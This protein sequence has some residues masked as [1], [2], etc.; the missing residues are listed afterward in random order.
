MP[1]PTSAQQ[2]ELLGVA[3][4][5]AGEALER[6]A[7]G[8]LAYLAFQG[9]TSRSKLAGLLWADVEDTK[10]RMNLRQRV[11][12]LK[13][14]HP[15]LLLG[16]DIL[17]LNPDVQVDALLEVPDTAGALLESHDYSDCEAFFEWL[18]AKRRSLEAARF[19]ALL[20][21]VQKLE[22]HGQF[23]DALV[24]A[25][26]LVALEPLSE[27]NH[28][29]VMRLH[30]FQSD[31]PSA[32]LAFE[33]CEEILKREL[34]VRPLPETIELMQLIERGQE[35]PQPMLAKPKIPLSVLRPPVLAGREHEWRALEI[36]WQDGQMLA[37][38]GEPGMGKTRLLLDFVGS[39]GPYT[40]IEGRP[41]DEAV[42]YSTFARLLRRTLTPGQTQKIVLL[43][44][45]QRQELA[46]IV[47]ELEPE[48]S[49]SLEIDQQRLFAALHAL[50]RS[51]PARTV[52]A[53][54]LQF[55][56]ANSLGI[57]EHFAAHLDDFR[58]AFAY[59]L[60]DLKNTFAEH[61]ENLIDAGK[62]LRLQLE[63]LDP[64]ALKTL[65]ECLKIDGVQHLE[66]WLRRYTGGN[67][68]YV[69][70][71]VKNLLES[72]PALGQGGLGQNALGQNMLGQNMLGQNTQLP[73]KPVASGKIGQL[74]QRRLERLSAPALRLARAAAVA[75]SDF[76]ADLA[77][78]VLEINAV[79]LSEPWAELEATQV[80]SGDAFAH[81]LIYEATLNGI[82]V[83]VKKL[84]HWRTAEHLRPE[85]AAEQYWKALAGASLTPPGFEIEP[86]L[87]TFNKAAVV[88]CLR[89]AQETGH[90][91]FERALKLAPNAAEA[92]RILVQQAQMLERHLRYQDA[93]KVLNQAETMLDEIGPVLQASVWNARAALS[94]LGFGD[95]RGSQ[96]ACEN[97][98]E[99]L[100]A[101][102][103][104]E[105]QVQRA[106]A[107]NYL[108]F[109]AW[110][111]RKMPEAESCH[112]QALEL[113]YQIGEVDKIADSLQN[114]SHV[115]I[116][117]SD[118]AAKALLQEAL[119]IRQTQ[120]HVPIQIRILS[121]L[122]WLHWKL[123]E[124]LKAENC[125]QQALLLTQATSIDVPMA[126]HNNLAALQFLQSRYRHAKQSYQLALDGPDARFLPA[127]RA[128][129]MG[130]IVETE[131]HLGDYDNAERNIEIGL[132]L[133][134]DDHQPIQEADLHWYA[135]ELE[136]LRDQIGPAL[137]HFQSAVRAAQAG[138]E[139]FREA[140][141]W[142]RMARLEAN[143]AFAQKA[144]E[145][146]DSPT[147]RAAQLLLEQRL[148][149]ALEQI[150]K[151]NDPYEE[152]RLL[153]DA[154]RLRNQPDLKE[155]ALRLLQEARDRDAENDV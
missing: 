128:Q 70:E 61:L 65:L 105:A 90:A 137:N 106:N 49:G 145:L 56:D 57:L 113:R 152:A 68:L 122:G 110:M 133:L 12:R 97:A 127:M 131:L 8:L 82:P 78:K 103:S 114:L 115:L 148:E 136:V 87:E 129:L 4:L 14:A 95:A 58:L 121:D 66:H 17:S 134:A 34:G 47:P 15:D 132:R 135:G 147:S 92:V 18:E 26:R 45:W 102:D 28:R 69:L 79:E 40:L 109:S 123:G 11:H 24:L 62:L 55:M 25:E 50:M 52:V 140:E 120:G 119:Q 151:T 149:E 9:A 96:T 80:L 63:P 155:I 125:F 146:Q 94:A 6:K 38:H 5:N 16:S 85:Q 116:D 7:A 41:G 54:D 141:S 101:L 111:Q 33:R 2:L 10:A 83:P 29:R 143:Q 36:A 139:P 124:L 150:R 98:L 117:R 59:R 144:L 72:T 118:P 22:D 108:G 86:V 130:N 99:A 51:L 43:A 31:R 77:A 76:T 91:W 32:I 60:G 89:G 21:Q 37:L 154:S 93:A 81:D 23:G 142:S 75:G 39:H 71:T 3:R 42:P 35:L 46:R 100:G 153:M 48:V 53:D 104:R 1:T 27:D 13:A 88:H 73:G 67:P 84:L 19:E 138:D 20:A 112:R 74:I 44:P 107:F 30:Y 126:L 64:Q